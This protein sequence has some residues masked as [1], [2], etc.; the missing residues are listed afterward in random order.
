V[1]MPNHGGSPVAIITG[2]SS[3]IGRALAV[4]LGSAGFRVG[5][6]ARR[7]AELDATAATIVSTGGIATAA[8]ADVGDRQALRSAIESV[9]TRIGPADVLVANAGFGAP[10][11][12]DPL[13]TADVEETIRVNLMGVI[14]S[15]EAVLPGM[16]ER[17]RGHLLAVSSLAAFKGLP[18]ESAYCASKAAVN[19]YMEGIR[20]AVRTR[21]V[22]VTTVCP[23]FVSTAMTPM[24]S[25][26]PFIISAED[27]AGRI[28]RLIVRRKGGL[29]CF[30]LPM[31][32]LMSLIARLPDAIVVR[33][34]GQKPG[35]GPRTGSAEVAEKV[36]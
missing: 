33:L 35:N 8:V 14:Y 12:L 7:R 11:R 13:N 21:G 36:T 30:P 6:I 34:I 10:T 15:I 31:T 2:A 3:G 23:G 18:G 29:V 19:G 20:I 26:T 16:L 9:E 4:Q 17:R 27:C 24:E 5:L 28:A 1:A 22:T 25:A 32:L